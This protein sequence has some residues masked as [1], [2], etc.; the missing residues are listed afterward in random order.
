MKHGLAI[1]LLF[2]C[3]VASASS[4]GFEG[5]VPDGVRVRGRGTVALDT[6]RYKD[7]ASS[8]R[9]SWTGQAE[10]LVSDPEGIDAFM[11]SPK[12][13]VMM[14]ICNETPL[15]HPLRITFRGRDGKDICWFDANAGFTGWRA[16]WVRYEDMWCADGPVG[17]IPVEMR[18]R[19]GVVM[20]VRP[21]SMSVTGS[22]CIDRLSFTDKAIHHQNTPDYVVPDNNRYITRRNIWHWARLWE[23]EQYPRLSPVPADNASL[24]R[25]AGQMED[26]FLD[27][28]PSGRDYKAV[29]YRPTLQKEFDELRLERLPDGTVKG[30]PVVSNDESTAADKRMQKV[31]NV[32]YRY[33]LDYKVTGDKAALGR[34]FLVADHLMWQG[35]DWGS[36][37]GTNH[38]FGYNIRGWCNS[39]WLLRDEIRAAGRMEEYRRALEYWSGVAECRLPFE[40]DRDEI[41]D[42]WNTLLIPKLVS[43]MLQDTP[44]MRQAYMQALVRWMDGSMRFSSGTLGGIKVDGTAFH[45]GGS[46]P[47][48]AEGAYSTLGTWFR[49]VRGT[50]FVP[51]AES[52]DCVKTGL[53]AMHRYCNLYDWGIGIGGRHPF[54][55]HIP[56]KVVEAFGHLA[57]LGDL[58]GSGMSCDPELGGAFL[59]LKGQDKSV[60]AALRK[61][62]IK[63]SALPEGFF[64]YNYGAF[65]IHRRNGW[66][67]TLKAY[68]SD[69]WGSEIYTKDNRYGR[70]QSYASVQVI[71]SG[72]PA[73]AKDSRYVEEGWDWNALPGTTTIHL[74]W[75]LLNS[76]LKGTLMERNISRFP[77]VSSLGGRNGCMAFTCTEKNRP[78]FCPGATVTASVF[79][80]DNR[81]VFI[82]TGI[83]NDSKYPTRTTLF[84]QRLASESEA[85]LVDDASVSGFPQLWRGTAGK[86]LVEDLKGNCY[87]LPDGAGLAIRRSHQTSPDNTGTRMG[88]GDFAVAFIE[89]GVSPENASYEYMMLVEPSASERKRYSRKAPYEVIRADSCAHV[90]RDIPTGTLAYI[91]YGGYEDEVI[92]IPAETIV[93]AAWQDGILTASVCTPDLGLT[94]KS[95]TTPEASSVIVKTVKLRGIYTL[96]EACSDPV[97]G[98]GV[99]CTNT[100]DGCTILEVS[101]R[102]GH[103]VEFR[104]QERDG[105]MPMRQ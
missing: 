43:C 73:S 68:N 19:G 65:G 40:K 29:G 91:S 22:I 24:D 1:G 87:L 2:L 10:L 70:Y 51:S 69:V 101:C 63:A 62:G 96:M 53:M 11:A 47:A 45:H 15:E 20:A 34:F 84:Q 86:T 25:L 97:F 18:A 83:S 35:L 88:E 60:Q 61:D 55:G 80:F 75:E 31:F 90:V 79:C 81:I 94:D 38:H 52:R 56:A 78:S 5:S 30:V 103:P 48:Y 17:D 82:G 72:S 36:G 42:S 76:P 105:V 98:T 44:D 50:S 67:L 28:M 26:F 102:H 9:F 3:A 6:D 71:N 39:L 13:G 54:G 41:V 21:S 49:L 12:G 100:D 27:E 57:V 95:F 16:V 14:W 4:F 93:M 64:V 74:P 33:A 99:R 7:G 46:Y 89:H 58:S 77:G 92:S 8:L 85:V 23:W 104:L 37:M 66:M 32:M 59:V